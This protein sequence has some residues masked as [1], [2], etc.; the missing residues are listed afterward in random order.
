MAASLLPTLGEAAAVRISNSFLGIKYLDSLA[1]TLD[2]A[3]NITCYRTTVNATL[4]STSTA[5]SC[6][7][8]RA[9]LLLRADLVFKRSLNLPLAVLPGG[10]LLA[11]FQMSENVFVRS[12]L[13]P[14]RAPSKSSE[15]TFPLPSCVALPRAMLA[16]SAARGLDGY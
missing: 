1:L 8:W 5:P 7:H 3:F 11:P 6:I 2:W 10:K 13:T 16:V 4:G 9:L 12:R 15:S 14:M